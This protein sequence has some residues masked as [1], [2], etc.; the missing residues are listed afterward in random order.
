MFHLIWLCR[1]K[2]KTVIRKKA[3]TRWTTAVI[4]SIEPG[5]TSSILFSCDDWDSGAVSRATSLAGHLSLLIPDCQDVTHAFSLSEIQSQQHN[6][7]VISRVTFYVS[8]K[9]RPSRRER[10]NEDMPVSRLLKQWDRLFLLKDI[11]YRAIKDPLTKHKRF[12]F[13]LPD[14]LKQASSF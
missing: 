5:L 14:S 1:E 12:Q 3:F 11:L 10:A 4:G 9:R 8:R 13:L 2:G 6:D 7:S